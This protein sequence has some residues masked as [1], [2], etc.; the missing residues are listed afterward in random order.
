MLRPPSAAGCATST[1]KPRLEVPVGHGPVAA[2][3]QWAAIGYHCIHT[4]VVESFARRAHPFPYAQMKRNIPWPIKVG[5]KLAFGAAHVHY[6]LLKRLRIVEF[7]RMEDESFANEIFELHVR[8]PL[9]DAHTSPAGTLLEL[10]PGDSI[11]TGI[12]GRAAGFP[13]VTLVDIGWFADLR[14]SAV[15]ALYASLDPKKLAVDPTSTR[16]QVQEQL[17][18]NGINYMVAGLHSLASIRPQTVGHSFSNAV[19]QHVDRGQLAEL[20]RL[21]GRLHVMGSLGSHAINFTDHFSG[22][23]VNHQL[24]HWVMESALVK[25]ANLYTNRVLLDQYFGLF[26]AAGFEIIRVAV[27]LFSERSTQPRVFASAEQCLLAVGSRRVMRAT[28]QVKKVMA[29]EPLP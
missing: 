14:P 4:H 16:E 29:P 9:R 27:D 12:L 25:R 18:L 28:V 7:G 17:R 11:A 21:L 10:G 13:S 24:P 2:A 26:Q 15:N 5:L 1:L 23:F 22:G 3:R 6:G 8:S 20:V 19:L